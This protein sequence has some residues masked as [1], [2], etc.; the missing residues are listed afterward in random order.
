MTEDSL[1]TLDDSVQKF[2]PDFPYQ[3]V[4]IKNMLDHRS[5]LPNY[6]YAFDDSSKTC[7]PPSNQT[8]MKWFAKAHP[9]RY[10]SPDRGFSYNNSNYAVLAAI[11][12]K[13][14]KKRYDNYLQDKIFTP[15]G[16][17]NTYV[18]NHIPDSLH[19]TVGHE[20]RRKINK[21]FFD[22]VVGDKGVYSSLNDLLLW[23]K[24]LKKHQLLS[25]ESTDMAFTPKSFEKRGTRNYGFGF[26]MILNKGTK[27]PKYIYHNGW[28]KGYSSLFWF[29]PKTDSL[30]VI[31]SNVKNNSVYKT[32][33]IIKVLEPE[34]KKKTAAKII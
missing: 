31:L 20:R 15:L 24:C 22:N 17:H 9:K 34:K 11:I 2:Y 13:V 12:E 28:W 1:L 33:G 5:G 10:R 18:I 4:T 29:N 3:G 7:P 19:V 26:R 30:I 8:I 25:E 14:S 21:D 6:L 32:K 16:M 23:Y 27:V